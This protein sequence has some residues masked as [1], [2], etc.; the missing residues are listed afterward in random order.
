MSAAGRALR[1]SATTVATAAASLKHGTSTATRKS[2]V[3]IADL[4][5]RLCAWMVLP[6]GFYRLRCARGG[7]TARRQRCKQQGPKREHVDRNDVI[8]CEDRMAHE[9]DQVYHE[10]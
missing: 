10:I 9:E 4:L 5:G 8:G 2:V 6:L 1:K 7:F 3:V